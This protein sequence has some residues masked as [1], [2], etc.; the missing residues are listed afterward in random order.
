MLWQ[1]MSGQNWLNKMGPVL[2]EE[3]ATAL[4]QAQIKIGLNI[5]GLILLRLKA[6]IFRQL[7]YQ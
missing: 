6:L 4:L 3:S 7:L 2:L 1:F 5:K